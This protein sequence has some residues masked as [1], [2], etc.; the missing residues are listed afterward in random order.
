MG[1]LGL[2]IG[3]AAERAIGSIE[4]AP[5]A[6]QAAELRGTQIEAFQGQEQRARRQQA[7]KDVAA[8]SPT[9]SAEIKRRLAEDPAA[10]TTVID[11]LRRENQFLD[12]SLTDLGISSG[13]AEAFINQKGEVGT[14]F[15]IALDEDN[16][17]LLAKRFSDQTGI[18]FEQTRS[19]LKRTLDAGGGTFKQTISD[20]KAS[21]TVEPGAPGV[22][23]LKQTFVLE[24]SPENKERLEKIAG[25]TLSVGEEL[26]TKTEGGQVVSLEDPFAV[27]QVKT[28][29]ELAELEKI[30][31]AEQ[32]AR[33]S[34]RISVSQG[35][36]ILDDWNKR[37]VV[38]GTKDKLS[39]AKDA[40]E[41]LRSENPIADSA[42]KR[43]LARLSGEVGVLTDKDVEDFAGSQAALRRLNAMAKRF[44]DGTFTDADRQD[45]IGLTE[46]LTKVQKRKLNEDASKFIRSRRITTGREAQELADI[47]APEL[48]EEEPGFPTFGQG[49]P[50]PRQVAQPQQAAPEIVDIQ[51]EQFEIIRDAQGTPV[52]RRRV[53]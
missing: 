13:V 6:V 24:V 43:S 46:V 53:Q 1:G 37:K 36:K 42:S 4:Q 45:M 29:K 5:A 52:S 3:Q 22:G 28:R 26:V 23:A 15:N 27:G 7:F 51:G 20:G 48:F 14:S 44:A 12:R 11:D 50:E 32:I 10:G 25:R 9:L 21:V 40:L 38:S 17:D 33:Q 18:P 31:T 30:V 16:I 2:G 39:S 8:L 41:L 49:Q 47:L 34:G 35:Q 19:S